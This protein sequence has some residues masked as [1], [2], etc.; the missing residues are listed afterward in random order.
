M[1][2]I[3][4][5]HDQTRRHFPWVTVAFLSLCVLLHIVQALKAPSE[6]HLQDLWMEQQSLEARV[7]IRFAPEGAVSDEMLAAV[8]S[9]ASDMAI[10]SVDLDPNV[11]LAAMVMSQ[12][13]REQLL[14]RFRAGDL[15]GLDDPLYERL[16][17]VDSELNS[18][19]R[20]DLGHTLGYRP[21]AGL[22]PTLVTSAFVHADW[23]HL[24]GNMLFLWLVGCNLED[25]WGRGP[26]A[27]FYLSGAA[28]AALA[29]GSLHPGSDIPLVGASG[30]VAA[31][32][33]AFLVCFATAEIRYF[34]FFVSI[35]RG[36]RSGTFDAPAFIAFPLWFLFQLWFAWIESYVHLG[37]AY[38]AHVGGFAF[39]AA[40]A[41]GLKYSGVE[42]THLLPATAAGAEWKEDDEYLRA[43]SLIDD[44][45]ATEAVPLLESVLARSPGHAGAT[46]K[47]YE[48]GLATRDE[49][50]VRRTVSDVIHD[51]HR[52]GETV[53]VVQIYRGVVETFPGVGFSERGLFEVAKAAASIGAS[54]VLVHA[55]RGLMANYPQ[56]SFLPSC[57]WDVALAQ[58]REGRG[59]LATKTLRRLVARHPYDPFADQARRKLQEIAAPP[60]R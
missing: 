55:A 47:L 13:E 44:N 45:K 17:D 49:S 52:A 11:G 8:R 59:D 51:S 57:L 7:V 38:S 31:A 6:A 28:V 16:T 15:V 58:Q 1:L 9:A 25:R 19:F 33:G 26:F 22:S 35:F 50:L 46:R 34:Y 23:L 14:E 20:N 32:M 21:S 40:V 29:Y 27:A 24:F 56:S 37:V 2:L 42:A 36:V 3:P 30:A 12:Q 48:H 5:S 53:E 41:L 18:Y 4:I 39:G 60:Y 54:P 43:R 10:Y